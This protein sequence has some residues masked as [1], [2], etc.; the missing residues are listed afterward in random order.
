VV[1]SPSPAARSLSPE[2]ERWRQ[3]ARAI[4]AADDAWMIV[5][6]ETTGVYNHDDIVEIAAVTPRGATL[7]ES[8]IRPTRP[9]SPP[10]FAVHRITDA[11]VAGAPAFADVYARLIHAHLAQRGILAYGASFDVRMLRLSIARHCR[12]AWQPIR[13]DDVM[14]AYAA[15][16]AAL[17][18]GDGRRA[19]KLT[20]ACRQ[21]GITHDDAHRAL[22]DCLATARLIQVMAR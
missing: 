5:D 18:S 3:W 7:F 14:R 19:P 21:M 10:A 22:P 1:A 17:H 4:L 6:V 11:M 16:H 9:I 20:E 2:H 15:Y 8:L 13:S 12:L